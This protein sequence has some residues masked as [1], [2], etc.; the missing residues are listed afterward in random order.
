MARGRLLLSRVAIVACGCALSVA[1]GIACSS[2][3]EDGLEAADG[4]PLADGALPDGARGDGPSIDASSTDAALT[5]VQAFD[6]HVAID[7]AFLDNSFETAIGCDGWEPTFGA[8]ALPTKPG[9]TGAQSCMVCTT[10]ASQGMR[11][12]VN[13]PSRATYQAL[14]RAQGTAD[15][16]A[17]NALVSL[18]LSPYVSP[19]DETL[20][21][22]AVGQKT[23]TT[24]WQLVQAV[25][26]TDA[27]TVRVRVA[28]I[29]NSADCALIDDVSLT[30]E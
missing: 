1:L 15:A 2:F 10:A 20:T 24:S 19:V 28:V 27:G 5:D 26:N 7:G 17:A 30:G 16:A 4:A 13:V 9:F 25:A 8:T 29:L 3:A 21:G 11:K 6:A 22:Y 12:F 18:E 23:L 14:M